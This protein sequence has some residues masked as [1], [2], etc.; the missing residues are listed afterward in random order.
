MKNK[1]EDL[2]NHLFTALEDLNNPEKKVDLARM[3]AIAD[4]ASVLV[5]SA[6][7]EVAYIRVTESK[8]TGFLPPVGEQEGSVAPLPRRLRG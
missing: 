5:E 6:K 8:G 1:M 4:I 3:D 2:R 7:V